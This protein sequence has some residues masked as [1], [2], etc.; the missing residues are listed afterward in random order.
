MNNVEKVSSLGQSIWIDYIERSFI[1]SGTLG[2]WISAGVRGLTSNPSIFQ[3]AI[4]GSPVYDQDIRRLAQ[5]S[6]PI[7][8]I[9]EALAIEDVRAAADLFLPIYRRSGGA[10]GYISLEVSP[11]L[12]HDTEGTV[13]EARRLFAAVDRPNLMIKI[14]ATAAGFPA[15]TRVLAAGINVNVTLIFGLHHYQ[16][17]AEAYISGVEQL[18]ASSVNPAAIA[19]VASF[20]VSRLDTAVD[21]WLEKSNI[22]DVLGTA[23]I[24]QSR[25]AYDLFRSIFS[26]PR[27]Q[28]LSHQGARVQRLLWASTSTKNPAY[29]DT[30]YVDALIGEDTVNTVPP[31]TLKAFQDH[32][33]PQA[34]LPADSSKREADLKRLTDLGIN[35]E[36][37]TEQLQQDGVAA[38]ADS[39]TKLLQSVEDKIKGFYS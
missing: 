29:S 36:T 4:S 39:F 38:F 31:D 15:I 6:K 16:Q 19:S 1:E 32:G 25:A 9:Y 12:A 14:P 5:Q 3:K 35:L 7:M 37:I 27:W 24:T 20:F 11:D 13:A 34:A 8:N 23:A 28:K 2:E 33:R 10:D 18:A 21:A 26:G 22:S 30:R 17:A